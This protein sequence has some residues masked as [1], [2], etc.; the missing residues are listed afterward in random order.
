MRY[1]SIL[2]ILVSR[3]AFADANTVGPNGIDSK[4][5]GLDGSTADADAP[6]IEIGQI[7]PGRSGKPN[8]GDPPE[9][10]ASNTNPAGVYFRAAGGMAMP[11]EADDNHATLVAGVMIGDKTAGGGTFV[12]V[13]PKANLHSGAIG[14]GSEDDVPASADVNFALAANRIAKLSGAGIRVR[15]INFSATRGLQVPPEKLDGSTHMTQFVDWSARQQ[16][17]LYAIAWGNNSSAHAKRAPTDNFNGMTI[18]ASEQGDPANGDHVYRKFGS[19]NKT[20]TQP[21]PL[22]RT[23]ISLIAPGQDVNVLG[24]N[25]TQFQVSGTSLAALTSRQQSPCYNNTRR[26]KCRLLS[27]TQNL[28][29]IHRSMK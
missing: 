15:A 28:A 21:D 5:T 20:L 22:P 3:I 25:D 12:G 16:D 17:I 10:A 29:Q 9:P 23:A 27:Q 18:A 19:I 26:D 13:A 6:G 8:Y 24:H 4:A 14:E 1:S 11:G 7:E 2:L